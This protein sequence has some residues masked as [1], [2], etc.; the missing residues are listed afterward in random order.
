M[1]MI[2]PNR[3]RARLAESRVVVGTMIAELRQSAVVQ[4]LA[5]AGID[6]A[7]IDNEHGVFSVETIS[8]LSRFARLV[9]VTPIVRIP[10]HTYE[11]IAQALDGGAQGIMIPRVTDPEQVRFAV[12]AAKYPPMGRR[13]SAAGRGHT[14]Y[15]AGDIVKMMEDANRES[16]VIV[17]IETREASE[18][19]DEI[20]AVPGVD[21]ALIGP[22]DLAIALGV[23]GR[24][25][26]P[27]LEEVIERTIAACGRH[28][29]L[30]AIHTNDTALTAEW[31]KRGMRLVS[32]SSDV[33]F[34]QRAAKEAADA[35]RVAAR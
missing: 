28:G 6:W 13:G 31:G 33:G 12:G 22:N 35:I 8:E 21:A 25:R 16:F 4:C 32:I 30:P 2:P 11:T 7:I 10:A 3:L 14:D 17:Q 23:P 24:M 18:R 19:L 9:G 34:L 1:S 15:K 29:V 20:L 26:D 5:N 27:V